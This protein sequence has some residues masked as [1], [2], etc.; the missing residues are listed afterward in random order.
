MIKRLLPLMTLLLPLLVHAEL[1]LT[2]SAPQE[3]QFD[4]A[5]KLYAQ[6]KFAD[7][8]VAYEKMIAT[9]S[10]SP[11]LYFNLGNARFKSGQLGQA[12]AAYRQ[13]EEMSPRDPDVRANLQFARNQVAGPKLGANR[14]QRW[15]GNL[16]VNEWVTLS[17][18][19]VWVTLGLL[20]VCQIKPVLASTL[21]SWIWLALASALAIFVCAR[22]AISQNASHKIGIVAVTEVT[23]R[24]GPFDESPSAFTAHDGAEL[25]VLDGKDSWLQ[26]TDGTSRVGWL[27][28]DTLILSPRF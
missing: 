9:G 19:A 12:I 3:A 4:A 1:V 22:L 5:N 20:I 7:A 21:R 16:S 10:I 15:L 25:R 28:R 13:A 14:L 26:I 23:V 8:A 18:G 11:A 24:N 2:N 27:K 17:T 6:G